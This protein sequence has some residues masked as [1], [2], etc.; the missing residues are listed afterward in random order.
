[1]ACYIRGKHCWHP[2]AVMGVVDI[3]GQGQ[4][5]GMQFAFLEIIGIKSHEYIDPDF[6]LQI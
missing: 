2:I 6:C 3:F 4:G 1:M 5:Q